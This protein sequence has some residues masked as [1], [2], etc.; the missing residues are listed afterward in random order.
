MKHASLSI[1]VALVAWIGAAGTASA[2]EFTP[3]EIARLNEGR[4]VTKPL[5]TSRRDG[6]YGGTGWAIVNAPVEVVWEA[7]QD[8][9]SYHEIFPH[10]V[11]V[12]E[13]S[14]KND[15]LLVRLALGHRLV[16][17]VYH[18]DVVR[19]PKKRILS[20]SL[21]PTLPHDIEETRGYWRLFPQSGGRTLVAYVVAAK[22][23]MGLINL[24]GAELERKLEWGILN[25]PINL[26]RWVEGPTGDR[27][28]ANR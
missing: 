5:P 3:K 25:L 28:R 12:R 13:L 17:C 19:D 22:V 4:S 11:A 21:V 20:F 15:R 7:I 2:V 14:R 26:K 27:Y 6:F 16:T 24:I 1:T 10:T 9:D 18:V 23:P 8:W